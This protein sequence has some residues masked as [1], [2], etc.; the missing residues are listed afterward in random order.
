MATYR[1]VGKDIQT[2]LNKAFDDADIRLPQ[3]IYWIQIVANRLRK[4]EYDLTETG[5][6]LST[7][8]SVSVSKDI[9]DRAYFDLPTPIMDLPNEGG[10]R[11]ITYNYDSGC[12]CS[13][14][15]FAQV[16]FQPTSVEK[17][18]ALYMD[19]YE[20]PS[21]KNPYFYVVGDKVDTVD[22]NRVYLVGVDCIH[23]KDVEIGILSSLDPSAVCNLDD[24]IPLPDERIEE[25][26]KTVIDIGR[27]AILM[28]EERVN[29]GSDESNE[30]I[31]ESAN[32]PPAPAV[33]ENDT[34]S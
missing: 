26:T 8:S 23:I 2:S 31:P 6:F 32:M 7:F 27:F 5:Q 21:P 9:K 18:H 3:I 17:V 29:Q 16:F 14:A 12:C 1:Y 10:I 19:E 30:K 34:S 11:Y 20:K 22:V 28:P 4:E 33:N 24:E 13:G 15:T 25:L